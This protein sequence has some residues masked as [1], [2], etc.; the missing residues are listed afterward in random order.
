M[1]NEQISQPCRALLS[2]YIDRLQQK[3]L[4]WYERASSRQYTLWHLFT[5]VAFIATVATSVIA[6]LMKQE[7]FARDGQLLLVVLPLIGAAASAVLTQFRFRELEDLR[8][9]GRIEMEDIMF[10]AKGLL[11]AAPDEPAC[12]RAYEET[13]KRVKALDLSQHHAD[14]GLRAGAARQQSRSAQRG[15]DSH[16]R[17]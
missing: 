4:R 13:R 5:L 8:E 12:Q 6:A 15:P 7:F 2:E 11:A 14:T 16:G 17:A 9:R 3:E 1:H 10:H